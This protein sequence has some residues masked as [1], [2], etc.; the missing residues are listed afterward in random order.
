MLTFTGIRSYPEQQTIDFTGKNFVAIVGDTGSGKSTVLDAI[1]YA[2]YNRCSWTS[3]S[4]SDLISDSG[5]GSIS[6]DFTFMVNTQVWRVERSTGPRGSAVHKLFAED[7]DSIAATGA[8]EVNKAI[9]RIVGLNYETF[10]RAVVL[11]QGRFAELLHLKVADRTKALTSV[12]GLDQLTA[13]REHAQT[14]HT[15]LATRLADY[16]KRRAAF[17]PDPAKTLAESSERQLAAQK[18]LNGLEAARK[19]ISEAAASSAKAGKRRDTYEQMRTRLLSAVPKGVEPRYQGLHTADIDIATRRQV[20]NGRLAEADRKQREL[21][22]QLQQANQEG[23]GLEAA[24]SAV[25]TLGLLA[26]QVPRIDAQEVRLAKVEDEIQVS[27]IAIDNKKAILEELR[28]ALGPASQAA[29]EASSRLTGAKERH[30]AAGK[31]L[32]EFRQ[33]SQTR[34]EADARHVAALKEVE[35]TTAAAAIAQNEAEKADSQVS[36]READQALA[37]KSHAAATAAESCAPGDPCPV[38]SRDLPVGFIAPANAAPRATEAAVKAARKTAKQA[39]ADV[40]AAEERVKQAMKEA[41]A[42]AEQR[43]RAAA[44]ASRTLTAT[45]EILGNVDLDALDDDLLR[46]LFEAVEAT[47]ARHDEMTRARTDARER[48]QTV[49]DQLPLMEQAHGQRAAKYDEDVAVHEDALVAL[50]QARRTIV[51]AYRPNSDLALPDIKQCQLAAERRQQELKRLSDD[52]TAVDGQHADLKVAADS[53]EAEKRLEVEYPAAALRRELDTLLDRAQEAARLLAIEPYPDGPIDAALSA[54][55]SWGSGLERHAIH[56]AERCGDTASEA[57]RA[58]TAARQTADDVR[59]SSQVDDDDHLE[60]MIRQASNVHYSAS[61]AV[62]K[63]KAHLPLVEELERRINGATPTVKALGELVAL[64]AP[65]KFISNAVQQRQRALLGTASNIFHTISGGKFG[66]A[67][68]FRIIDT[69]AGQPRPVETLSGGETFQASLALALA[70]VELASRATGR[71][72]SL[73]LDEGFGSLDAGVLRDALHALTAH[74]TEG[75]LVTVI[76]HMR[77]ITE[78]ADHV[79]VVEKTF[80][81]SRARWASPEERDRIINDDLSRGMLT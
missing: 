63:A 25:T 19:R 49:E 72:D 23:T 36:A 37:V 81:G 75:R 48:C 14:L 40:A 28:E 17:L 15:Q 33:A 7:L 2:L 27:Q 41:L 54:E 45:Q 18:R 64:L 53:L 13:V 74:S 46:G 52:L 59:R 31:V 20:L 6:V 78:I 21:R 32:S 50:G 11:P 55:A 51:R 5:N 67:P 12:L 44:N 38:C 80:T 26:E 42:A 60:S 10:L 58:I 62:V 9:R 76:S 16:E 70:V 39:S 3:G 79:L 61:Q 47:Q 43:T 29:F 73:F 34:R 69:D 30:A 1:C 56:L 8:K 65:S 24:T 66:F 77:A 57:V 68:N 22:D 71:L 35:G 4:V